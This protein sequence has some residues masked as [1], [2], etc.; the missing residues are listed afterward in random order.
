MVA[1]IYLLFYQSYANLRNC[2]TDILAAYALSADL[3]SIDALFTDVSPDDVSFTDIFVPPISFW[4]F[5]ANVWSADVFSN[6]LL[7]F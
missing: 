2:G 4:H 7:N 3:S 5:L 6:S 1:T